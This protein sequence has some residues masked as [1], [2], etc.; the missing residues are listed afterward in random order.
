VTPE[1]EEQFRKAEEYLRKSRTL[2][3]IVEYP[4]ESGPAA[5][6]AA[7]HAAQALI[8]ERTGR[9]ARKHAGVRS[10][11]NLLTK[12]D[13][14][15]DTVLRR[16]LSDGFRLKSVADYGSGPDAIVSFEEARAA[17][18]TGRFLLNASPKSSTSTRR[19]QP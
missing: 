5:Y 16:F 4:D 1:S 6:L 14:R 9:I 19:H 3:E 10:Q 11:F 8:S 12:E 18:A 17:I 7:F 13:A 15:F 2:L